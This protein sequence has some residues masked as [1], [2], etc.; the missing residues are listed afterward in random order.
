MSNLHC[1]VSDCANNS[2]NFCCRPDIEVVGK[3]A[4]G[5]EQTSCNDFQKRQGASNST[6][7]SSSPNENLD[8][9][10]EAENCSYNNKGYCDASNVQM[11]SCSTHGCTDC[12]SETACFTFKMQQSR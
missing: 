4:C 2:E 12:K 6:A 11:T 10:C 7:G 5:C 1:S 3:S 9:H 8:V